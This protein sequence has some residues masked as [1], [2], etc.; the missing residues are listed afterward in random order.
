MTQDKQ[1]LQALLSFI[2][3]LVKEPGNE[4]FVLGVK[5]LASSLSQKVKGQSPVLDEI[6]EICVERI[7]H[8][9]AE[10]FYNGF[11]IP[12][13]VHQ[14]MEDYIKM[15]HWY[16]R[17][18]FE[19]FCLALYQQYECIINK[20][21]NY[22][23]LSDAFLKLLAYHAYTNG[24]TYERPFVNS[25]YQ[26]HKLIFYEGK[27]SN[28]E[29]IIKYSKTSL[30]EQPAVNK[31]KA[32]LYLVTFGGKMKYTDF[33]VFIDRGNL[34]IDLYQ[35]R[36]KNH[37]GGT[38]TPNQQNACDRVKKN[39]QLYA[40]KM[41][42]EFAYFVERINQNYNNLNKLIYYASKLPDKQITLYKK[43]D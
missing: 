5:K 33:Q 41:L 14:L 6:Y 9:D 37:R 7:A 20:L 42:G 35:I 28:A 1:K 40:L 15:E 11:C 38:M 22:S 24:L 13:I 25:E 23:G 27:D 43:K 4:E 30:P 3:Q 21:A 10:T 36:C 12:D 31:Y 2:S 8:N 29:Q 17:G 18:N 32:I 34:F 16:R 26:L 39:C 19:E